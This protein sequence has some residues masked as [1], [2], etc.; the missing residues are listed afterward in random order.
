LNS[1]SIARKWLRTTDDPM[2]AETLDAARY[3][4]LFQQNGFAIANGIFS[5]GDVDRLRRAIDA[6]PAGEEVRRKRSVYG[7]RN[8][9]EISPVVRQL[10]ADP[11][12]RQFVTPIL[13]A[14]AFAVRAIYFDKTPDANW[15]LWW[16]QDNV[17]SVKER[18]EV[19]GF[20]GW[21]NKA[22]VW[23]VQPPAEILARMVAVRVHL[24]DCGPANGPLRVLPG[25]HRHG[26]LDDQIDDWKQ[27]VPEIVCEVQLG[28]VVVMCPLI[29][30]A[31]APAASADH[32]RVIH[33]EFATA[34]LPAGLEWNEHIGPR[35]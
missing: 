30:H 9:L 21:S 12:T 32:R 6:L 15:S 24:D 1:Q 35:L 7:V 19:P 31:S 33:I 11:R 18:K 2:I 16:H 8:L 25:S 3:A 4:E 14:G 20:V 22:G 17:I 10:A 23:Q 29:L 27:R 5:T 34:Q 13:G 28:G 26:W